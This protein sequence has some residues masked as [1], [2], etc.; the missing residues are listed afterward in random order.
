MMRKHL[1]RAR[2][3][4]VRPKPAHGAAAARRPATPATAPSATGLRLLLPF[5]TLAMLALLFVW[6]RVQT[7]ELAQEIAEIEHQRQQ[8][9]DR[10]EKLLIQIERLSSY[11]RIAQIA[12]E[13]Y[14]LTQIQPQLLVVDK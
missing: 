9:I 1:N 5:V 14:G 7:H 11:G 13:R 4:M 10:N 8:L 2:G 6:G 12:G 3:P